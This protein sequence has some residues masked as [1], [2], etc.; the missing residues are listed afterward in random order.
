MLITLFP[1]YLHRLSRG[2]RLATARSPDVHSLS[3]ARAGEGVPHESLLNQTE[4]HRDGTRPLP[5][6]ATDQ[7]L[8]SESAYEVEKGKQ[9]QNRARYAHRPR[10]WTLR[11]ECSPRE[12]A[13]AQR[14][15]G[16]CFLPCLLTEGPTHSPS[17]NRPF[18]FGHNHTHTFSLLPSVSHKRLKV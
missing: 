1:F 4:T 14:L 17:R 7:D 6:R 16:P 9:E 15:T 13:S 2:N 8:V 3:D 11:D 5:H 18:S 10:R 12:L